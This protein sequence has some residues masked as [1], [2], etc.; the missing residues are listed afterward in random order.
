MLRLL[1]VR[2]FSLLLVLHCKLIFVQKTGSTTGAA[3]DQLLP[4]HQEQDCNGH[5]QLRAQKQTD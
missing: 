3:R 1:R 4:V 5:G 2:A